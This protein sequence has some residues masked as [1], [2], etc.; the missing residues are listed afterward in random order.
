MWVWDPEPGIGLLFN[1]IDKDMI[2]ICS[3]FHPLAVTYDQF[4]S[5][6]SIQ[7]LRSHGINTIQTSFNRGFKNKIYQNLKDMMG[8]YPQPE[9]WLY[10]DPRLILEMKALKYRPTMRGISLVKDKHGEVKTDDLID[11][12]AGAT[13]SAAETLRASLPPP[14]TVNMGFR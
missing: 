8:Y 2:H 13:A 14:V 4:N 3:I 11:C 5:I 6:Q 1:Q 12:L 7:M 10:D 9:L